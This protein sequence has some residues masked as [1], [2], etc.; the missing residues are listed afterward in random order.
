LAHQIVTIREEIAMGNN[1]TVDALHQRFLAKPRSGGDA[2]SPKVLEVDQDVGSSEEE[3]G[4]EDEEMQDVSPAAPM[5]IAPR[6]RLVP[7]IDE[8]GFEVVQKKGRR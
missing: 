8:D 7:V 1:T 5:A 2:T 3:G 4:D 6:E